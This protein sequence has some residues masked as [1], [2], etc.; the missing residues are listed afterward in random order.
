MR[1]FPALA[2]GLLLLG[3]VGA[4]RPHAAA[5]VEAT[6][7]A[8]HVDAA[9]RE[10]ALASAR[11]WQP[12]AVPVPEANLARN[13]AI[14]KGFSDDDE[15]LCRFT[16]R[17]VGGTTPKFY[18]ELPDGTALKI[19]YGSN[20]PEL[21]AEVAAS[22]L[23]SAL[24]FYADTMLVV[25]RVRCAGCPRF[26]FQAL[27][28]ADRTGLHS[29][30]FLGGLDFDRIGAFAAAVVERKLEG[31]IIEAF[32]DQGWAWY[33]LDRI[34]PAL[35]GSPRAEVDAFR[36]MAVFLAHWDNKAANQRL[37]CPG[38]RDA[39]DGGCAHPVAI[40]Q[41]L[42]ATFGPLKIDLHHW[43]TGRIWKDAATCTVSMEH[44]PWQGATFPERQVTEAGR[45]MLL[46]LLEQLTDQQL[47]ELFEGSRVVAFDQF[48]GEGRG[49]QAWV[50]AFTDRVDQIRTA[51]PCPS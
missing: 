7:G 38:G 32:D 34:D 22:R 1:P 35:G 42:G 36:L 33:E 39:P 21:Y 45:L 37:I 27:R 5:P 6:A 8:E 18:C 51:G 41:D 20:N 23:L 29:A 12:T 4:C 19:K 26:P 11:V 46:G 28:C 31:R 14:P 49:A 50:A 47:R 9:T 44:F 43:R 24:G 30:C 48:M 25:S 13:P 10:A 2:A 16:P 15:I 3:S 17:E 40:M